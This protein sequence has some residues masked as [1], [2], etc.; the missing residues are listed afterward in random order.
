[1][2]AGST[3]KKIATDGTVPKYYFVNVS[4]VGHIHR[5][6]ADMRKYGFVSAGGGKRYSNSLD[7]LKDGD[8]IFV[9]QGLPNPNYTHKKVSGYVGYG[10]VE[11]TK[12]LA[13]ELQVSKGLLF[14]Q[15][16]SQPGLKHHKDDQNLAEYAVRVKWIETV[17]SESAITFPGIFKSRHIACKMRNLE[18]I[19]FLEEKFK[20]KD[21]GIGKLIIDSIRVEKFKRLKNVNIS[22]KP[23]TVIIGKNS[24][25]KS[26]YLH[27]AQLGICILQEAATSN[28]A[29][30]KTSFRNTMSFDG[31]LFRPTDNLLD[32]NHN[33]PAT[34]KTGY[35]ILYKGE[36]RSPGRKEKVK[37]HLGVFRGKNANLSFK[38]D[39]DDNFFE[40]L[41]SKE[42]PASVLASGISGVSI[43][44]E[45]KTKPVVD[46]AAMRGDAN[47][48]LRVIL[49]HLY[50]DNLW[51]KFEEA[52]EDCFNGAK[53]HMNYIK[54]KDRYIDVKIEYNGTIFA[55]D[56]AASGM[57][58]VI[59]IL[60]YAFFYKPPLLL[61]DEP[62][63]HLHQDGQM[64]LCNALRRIVQETDTRIVLATHSFQL[65]QEF[66]DDLLAK[67]VLLDRGKVVRYSS[68]SRFDYHTLMRYGMLTI[69]ELEV[70]QGIKQVLLT[71]D[72]DVDMIKT[73]AFEN[74]AMSSLEVYSYNGCKNI[75]YA[76]EIAKY[77]FDRDPDM[78]IFVHRDR[79]FRTDK[80]V[81]FEIK[82]S[83][84]RMHKD[85]HFTE[86]FTQYSDIEHS[87]LVPGHL[88]H[89]FSEDFDAE[90]MTKLLKSEIGSKWDEMMDIGTKSRNDISSSLYSRDMKNSSLWKELDM[91]PRA[92]KFAN[93]ISKLGNREIPFD[94][95]RGKLLIGAVKARLQADLGY[96][97]HYIDERMFLPTKYLRNEVWEK[98]FK[99]L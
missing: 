6:W 76:Y 99:N 80:E 27:A 5:S 11:S 25:G 67:I 78:Q 53:I 68:G 90:S 9:Y 40:H 70:K 71:E 45:W 72:E 32:L 16:L 22:L 86:I 26:S 96:H 85:M 13:S 91:P 97:H 41:A 84:S 4:A 73:L 18:T 46:A 93:L 48:Y 29:T 20:I 38:K 63:V 74:G 64:R 51:G 24:S 47:L 81:E 55:L 95:C 89:V 1:M 31:V 28:E 3:S 42:N 61:L 30:N 12:T 66:E 59:Q 60:A 56:L 57:L 14:E 77:I 34:Q 2:M 62:D 79:D 49:S 43:R 37:A 36:L 33:E 8:K 83:R 35:S 88:A 65:V 39:G 17:S 87:F 92:P 10:I 98:A 50:E 69:K 94:L 75:K 7:K 19:G 15:K 54:E 23:I 52:F 58:Q 44:E 21:R 82:L